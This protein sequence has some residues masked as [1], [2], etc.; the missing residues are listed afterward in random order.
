[1]SPAVEDLNINYSQPRLRNEGTEINAEN[2]EICVG[3][4]GERGDTM[5]NG[6][7]RAEWGRDDEASLR[8]VTTAAYQRLRFPEVVSGSPQVERWCAMPHRGSA[9]RYP[10]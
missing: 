4:V 5:T 8:S 10:G 9:L 2:A 7:R 1:M 6:C 3:E